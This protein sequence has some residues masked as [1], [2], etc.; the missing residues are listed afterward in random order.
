M[1]ATGRGRSAVL[2]ALA[3]ALL[4]SAT[5]GFISGAAPAGAAGGCGPPVTS[6]IACEN[7]QPG[8]PR[9]DWQ[10]TG[11]GDAAL[12]GFSTAMSVRPGDTVSFKV[13]ATAAAYHV[14]ILRFGYYQGNGA[15]K[16]ATLAGPFPRNT[17]PSCTD[18]INTGLIDCGSW[19]V[20]VTWAVPSSA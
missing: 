12:P 20:S 16:V 13:S 4:V 18:Q 11:S 19:S 9:G 3:V 5:T 6:V 15:R 14:D 17:Q 2:R 7:A 10:G 1:V 8:D